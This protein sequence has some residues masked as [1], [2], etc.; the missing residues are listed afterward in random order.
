MNMLRTKYLAKEAINIKQHTRR[1][2][3][4]LQR[5]SRGYDDNTWWHLDYTLAELLVH[6]LPMLMEKNTGTVMQFFDEEDLQDWEISDAAKARAHLKR[7]EVFSKIYA[8][9]KLYVDNGA[10]LDKE[11]QA[12]VDEALK[13][14]A[15]Y[16]YSLWD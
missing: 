5:G 1:V 10:P 11:E 8:G 3:H 7:R 16:F 14:L 12:Q 13:L 2:K 9:M 15:E 6:N 4:F